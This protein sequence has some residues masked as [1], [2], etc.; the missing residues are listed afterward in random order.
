MENSDGVPRIR[1]LLTWLWRLAE[2]VTESFPSSKLGRRRSCW[3]LY[4]AD[5]DNRPRRVRAKDT[6]GEITRRDVRVL[7][8]NRW[9]V[10]ANYIRDWP[11]YTDDTHLKQ[12]KEKSLEKMLEETFTWRLAIRFPLIPRNKNNY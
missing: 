4:E 12:R 11:T 5:Y 7:S 8:S 6:V 10:P 2:P 3:E 9:S 1:L